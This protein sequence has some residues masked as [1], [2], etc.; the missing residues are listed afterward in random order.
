M[1]TIKTET[2]ST[3]SNATVPVDTVVNGTAKAWVNFNGTST[4]AIRRAFNVS[5]IT[6][7]ATGAYTVNFTT[8]MVDADYA[9]TY[10]TGLSELGGINALFT[11][12]PTTSSF[13]VYTYAV[14]GGGA[15]AYRDTAD[16]SAVVHI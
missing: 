14:A 16:I 3:P 7:L 2:L 9:A 10:M 13:S 12:S 8:A 15:G 1:S 11:I 6:D 5:S 4:V